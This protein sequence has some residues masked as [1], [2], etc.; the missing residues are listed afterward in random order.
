MESVG[1][2]E[3]PIVSFFSDEFFNFYYHITGLFPTSFSAFTIQRDGVEPGHKEKYGH[4][5]TPNAQ[6]AMQTISDLKWAGRDPLEVKSLLKGESRSADSFAAEMAWRELYTETIDAFRDVWRKELREKL[7]QYAHS[8]A[9]M[10]D[11]ISE[12]ILFKLSTFTKQKYPLPQINVYLVDCISAGTNTPNCIIIP[13]HTD[14]DVEK[15]LLTHELAHLV[16]SESGIRELLTTLGVRTGGFNDTA[17]A[18]IDYLAYISSRDHF[19]N[20]SRRGLRPNRE[21]FQEELDLSAAFEDYAKTYRSYNTFE[22]FL[23]YAARQFPKARL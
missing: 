18:I 14:Q 23:S 4:M 5:M 13:P 9:A 6:Q 3:L 10:W 8:L 19:V 20:P 11:P 1:K 17:H 21:Y 22:E 7:L 2:S 12:D 16:A 15:K